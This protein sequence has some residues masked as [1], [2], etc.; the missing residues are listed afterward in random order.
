IR[1]I[2][3]RQKSIIQEFPAE[4]LEQDDVY[5]RAVKDLYMNPKASKYLESYQQH[6]RKALV[7]RAEAIIEAELKGGN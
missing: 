5:E 1:Y 2:D 6:D 3:I 7:A 4:L